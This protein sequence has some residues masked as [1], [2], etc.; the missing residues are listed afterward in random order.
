MNRRAVTP[1]RYAVPFL[2]VCAPARA[3]DS[4]YLQ[5]RINEVLAWNERFQ[6]PGPPV[7]P[8]FTT[9][10]L[11]EL[12]NPTDQDLHLSGLYLTDALAGEE[13]AEDFWR[14]PPGSWI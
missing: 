11:V 5:L 7:D 13:Q 6:L 14:F 1:L 4:P 2:L 12:Y 3:A 8:D 10:D 9:P